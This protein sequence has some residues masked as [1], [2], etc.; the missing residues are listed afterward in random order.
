MFCFAW[1][2][3]ARGRR[4]FP[5][6]WL[7]GM[8]LR[9][10][11][12]VTNMVPAGIRGKSHQELATPSAAGD[13]SARARPRLSCRSATPEDAQRA[14]K[15]AG[16]P[17]RLPRERK[18]L[19]KQRNTVI[20]S[21]AASFTIS[22]ARQRTR[23]RKR[24][25]L[26]EPPCRFA[27]DFSSRER[28][29][30]RP[31]RRRDTSGAKRFKL[32]AGRTGALG[33]ARVLRPAEQS[34][35]MDLI[36]SFHAKLRSL[37]I[38]LDSETARLQ[39]ALHGE[40][41]DIED[42]PVRI[43]YDLLSE[44]QTLKDDVILLLDKAS[45]ESQE[46]IGFIKATKVLMKKNSM[47]IMKITEFFQK[48]GYNPRAKKSSV[49]EQEI[50][51]SDSESTKHENV[52]MPDVKDSLS[53]PAIPSTAS[54]EK[55]PRS[56][57]LSDFGLERYMISQVP[58]NPPQTVNDHEEEP[59]IL[60]PSSKQ[61]VVKVLKTPK[62]A[63]KMDDFECVTPKLEH[64]GISDCTACLNEDY[65]MGLK[66]MKENKSEEAIESEPVTSN[67]FFATPGLIIQQLKKNDG[68]YTDSPLAP[69]FCT[70]GLKIPSTKNSIALILSKYNSNLATP[71]AVR[72]VPP[73]K[74][75]LAK[76]GAPS[77]QSAGN[78]ENW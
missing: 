28:G 16:S 10:R 39:R 52:Q 74:A 60:T 34:L 38:T 6:H 67:H 42:Y 27:R 12:A 51:D 37:A 49:D 50:T 13:S 30:V 14:P 73:G 43:L 61:S 75:F 33:S 25:R 70:P 9:R 41:S 45:L 54:S 53:N 5:I 23:P 8:R 68:D 18:G 57:Q 65:T 48:Y 36:R 32:V 55:S 31:P 46:S 58:P 15:E 72:A 4:C 20:N 69:T 71:V 35:S 24:A 77:V 47:D 22:P 7:P 11:S 19:L 26:P 76:Y 3:T 21:P 56:P 62:C 2:D 59:R 63:L 40:E 29:L 78:K 44:V 64:F 1:K 17:T 66:N